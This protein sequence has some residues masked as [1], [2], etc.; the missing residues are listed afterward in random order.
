MGRGAEE[1][2]VAGSVR[3][4]RRPGGELEI[5]EAEEEGRGSMQGRAEEGARKAAAA[6][7][8]TTY[9]TEYRPPAGREK[10]RSRRAGRFCSS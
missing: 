7:T 10:K 8:A 2:P 6:A 3:R 1:G 4:G 9:T 5:E